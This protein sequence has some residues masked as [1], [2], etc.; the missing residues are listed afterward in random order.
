LE[1][2][3]Y[4]HALTSAALNDVSGHLQASAD[5]YKR[6]DYREMNGIKSKEKIMIYVAVGNRTQAL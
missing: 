1:V 5:L 4:L 2:E 6:R 3:F